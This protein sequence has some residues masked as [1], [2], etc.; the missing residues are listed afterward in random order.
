MIFK[1]SSEWHQG[2]RVVLGASLGMGTGYGL[3]MMTSGLF[4]KPMQ[5]DL[6]WSR[7][8][9]SFLPIVSVIS[10]LML[11]L[12]GILLDRFGAR[13]VAIAGL[14][15]MV[16]GYF[17]FAGVPAVPWM[18]Y[19]V[20]AL[21]GIV[22]SATGGISWTRGVAT[23]FTANR[24]T[25][26][27][28]AMCGTSIISAL[29]M[30]FLSE[31]IASQGWRMGFMAL[32]AVTLVVGVPWA[33]LFFREKEVESSLTQM[34][35]G[36]PDP[37]FGIA[38][39][40]PRFWVL[41]FSFAMISLPLGGFMIHLVPILT[42]RGI[43]TAL[44][45]KVVSAFAL[46]IAVGRVGAGFLLDRIWPPGVAAVCFLL[47]ILG[48][49]LL[50]SLESGHQMAWLMAGMSGVLIGLAQGAEAD[51]IAFFTARFF[52]LE[53]YSRVFSIIA[54]GTYGL[55]SLGGIM[56]SL[57]HDWYGNHQLSMTVAMTCYLLGA[58]AIFAVEKVRL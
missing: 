14:L 12:T 40:S 7:T 51:F 43:D 25:A 48:V 33:F 9:L 16:L 27:G 44:A 21:M 15:L 35:V 6:G 46:S 13:I 29:I 11:P 42:D 50:Q 53:V 34:R 52:P 1:S 36:S 26:F 49:L 23:W 30:P 19:G 3:L 24:G 10:A 58:V 2:W 56:F 17:L 39:R 37:G 32:A 8:A 20:V 4:L 54:F 18:F 38:L 28:I 31:I 57:F 47:P 55:I 45:A 22:V 41:F 5:E